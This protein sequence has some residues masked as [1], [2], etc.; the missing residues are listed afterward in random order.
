MTQAIVPV[1]QTLATDCIGASDAAAAL[2]CDPYRSPLSVFHAI[3]GTAEPRGED[4]EPALWGKLLEPIVR[5]VYATRRNVPVW[6]PTASYVAPNGWLRAT[7]DGIVADSDEI[8]GVIEVEPRPPSEL[9]AIGLLQVK[10][11]SAYLADLWED[12]IPQRVEIQSRVEMAVLSMCDPKARIGWCDVVCL[13]GGQRYVGPFRVERDDK[14]ERAILRDLELFW[15]RAKDGKEPSVDASQAWRR[16]ASERMSKA[17]A[18]LVVT[19]SPDDMDVTKRLRAAKALEADAKRVKEEMTSRI[20]MALAAAGATGLDAH[21]QGKLT[22]YKSGAGFDH[23]GYI[24]ELEYLLG[25]ARTVIADV[26]AGRP[27]SDAIGLLLDVQLE[28]VRARHKREH[29]GW[30]LRTPRSWAADQADNDGEQ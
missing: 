26:M 29:T 13:L 5:G 9:A 16:Y 11:T 28:H 8:R 3:R 6:V 10:T 24:G 23:A 18:K 1:E 17:Q 14:I 22:A 25:I 7:P 12:W 30:S 4:A 21:E 19:A 20:L 2:G 15:S 27:M